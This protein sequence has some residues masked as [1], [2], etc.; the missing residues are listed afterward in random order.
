MRREPCSNRRS[1][2]T[3]TMPTRWPA[4]PDLFM[5]YYYAWGTAAT[6]YDAK[7]LGQVDRAIAL[8]PD[9][10]CAYL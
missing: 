6:D 5:D 2:S 1:Q 3:R 9:N 10:V 4:P 8:A 7:V